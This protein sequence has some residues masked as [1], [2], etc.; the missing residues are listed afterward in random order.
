MKR[1]ESG[2]ASMLVKLKWW[3][4]RPCSVLW[5]YKQIK[6]ESLLPSPCT[7]CPNLPNLGPSLPNKN[8]TDDQPNHI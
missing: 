7:S 5:S 3:Y 1:G 2:Q 8:T 6:K 4:T